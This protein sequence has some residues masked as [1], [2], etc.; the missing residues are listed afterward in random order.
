LATN[1]K[2][3]T[4]TESNEE[5]CTTTDT[6]VATAGDTD[7]E[8]DT[9]ADTDGETDTDTD[10]DTKTVQDAPGCVQM[11]IAIA[12]SFVAVSLPFSRFWT[13]GLQLSDFGLETLD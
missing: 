2:S 6:N 10:T 1:R 4:K 9:A 5:C 13:F 8:A 11:F 3:E 12:G 7:A